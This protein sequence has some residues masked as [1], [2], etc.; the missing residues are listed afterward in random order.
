MTTPE[1]VILSSC[2]IVGWLAMGFS[3]A[4]TALLLLASG[5]VL[6]TL[7]LAFVLCLA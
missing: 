1:S 5:A 4:Q 7:W 6:F 2:V 3:F